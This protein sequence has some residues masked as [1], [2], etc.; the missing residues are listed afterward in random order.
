MSL[1][2]QKG[3]T[4][5][6]VKYGL[7]IVIGLLLVQIPFYWAYKRV[8]V[9]QT[10]FRGTGIQ[11]VTPKNAVVA[12]VPEVEAAAV[13]DGQRAGDTYLQVQIPA[14]AALDTA[15]FNRFMTQIT[16]WV[17]PNQGC[18][19]CHVAEGL[20]VEA[21][22]TKIVSRRMIQMVQEINGSGKWANHL[23]NTKVTCYTCHRG[24]P[25]PAYVWYTEPQ[26]NHSGLGNDVGQNKATAPGMTSMTR[27]PFTFSML[28]MADPKAIRVMGETSLPRV[29]QVG[30]GATLQETERTYSLMMHVS[31]ALGS[32]CTYCHNTQNFASWELSRTQRALGWQGFN[33]VR[34][35]NRDW[36]VPLLPMFSE[37]YIARAT[38][39]AG[40]QEFTWEFGNDKTGL[41]RLGP[42]GDAPKLNCGTCHNG[43]PL[44]LNRANLAETYPFLLTLD[45]PPV[46]ARTGSRR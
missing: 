26:S 39:A 15:D 17:S 43:E 20:E 29:G 41:A 3:P 12:A 9:Q 8:D 13:P 24:N 27:D 7:W 46:Q 1:F 32:N 42:T 19:Y 23:I 6:I 38:E 45:A 31:V 11:T 44:P 21:P 10:G 16:A 33:M 30:Q 34:D 40:G 36:I 28:D 22:Y 37:P 14:L 4:P 25:I 35:L 2:K 5:L 18:Y